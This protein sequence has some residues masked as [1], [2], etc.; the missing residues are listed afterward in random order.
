VP[1]GQLKAANWLLF[2]NNKGVKP[3]PKLSTRFQ[4]LSSRYRSIAE[5]MY[6]R[7]LPALNIGKDFPMYPNKPVSIVSPYSNRLLK[8]L[9]PLNWLVAGFV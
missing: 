9:N 2:L 6:P 7:S 5:L 3:E 1:R 8:P 4:Q